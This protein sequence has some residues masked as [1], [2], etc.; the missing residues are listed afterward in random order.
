MSYYCHGNDVVWDGKGNMNKYNINMAQGEVYWK[1]IIF[2]NILRIKLDSISD[3]PFSDQV[4]SSRAIFILKRKRGTKWINDV[5][6]LMYIGEMWKI[7]A[8][9]LWTVW[10]I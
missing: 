2:L 10:E 1:L 8:R 4:Q 3:N 7:L 6:F 5:L 9:W